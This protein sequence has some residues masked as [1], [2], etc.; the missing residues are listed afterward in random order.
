M[1]TNIKEEY[2]SLLDYVKEKITDNYLDSK[3]QVIYLEY[4]RIIEENINENA[5]FKEYSLAI[6]SL[7]KTLDEIKKVD[8]SNADNYVELK[9]NKEKE[10]AI[11]KEKS[12]LLEH[13]INKLEQSNSILKKKIRMYKCN[14]VSYVLALSIFIGLPVGM[15]VKA[16]NTPKEKLYKT[17]KEIHTTI[18]KK[19]EVMKPG[20]IYINADDIATYKA[21]YE[22][23]LPY[24]E[25]IEIKEYSP[26]ITEGYESK[27]K[28]VTILKD[29]SSL[30]N[31]IYERD[32][33]NLV[34]GYGTHQE[35]EY[36]YNKDIS[37]DDRQYTD[38]IYEITKLVQDTNDYIEKDLPISAYTDF[39]IVV[40]TEL[41]IILCEIEMTE[42]TMLGHLIDEIIKLS[43]NKKISAKHKR[44]LNKLMY[45]Y[46]NIN[47][48]QSKIKKKEKNI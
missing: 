5:S 36:K 12:D 4:I 45:E 11:N 28:V 30:D 38:K 42:N 27:R 3:S 22:E 10:Q 37:Y 13:K 20:Y 16:K 18:D 31:K 2:Q 9:E 34:L 48:R 39:V 15:Y 46:L 32:L 24:E 17:Y 44:E 33:P 26:W 41:L 35:Y 47:K 43:N 6:D 8:H 1:D 40:L 7:L 23:L 29:V 19:Y 21:S 25:T 14:V